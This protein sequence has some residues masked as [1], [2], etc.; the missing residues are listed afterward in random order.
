[1][2]SSSC[3]SERALREI[4]L[5]GFEIAVRKSS[6]AF[7]MNSYNLINGVHTSERHDLITDVLRSEFGFEGAVMTDWIVP[8]MTNKNSEWSYPDPAKVAAAG[9]SVFMPGTKHDYE[10]ILTGHKTG[11][12]TREQLEINVTRLLQ[13]AS[14]Q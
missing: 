11:K 13:F 9:T 8:G 14:E 6:P 5:R 12:V 2:A 7:V 4:Y 3:V 1:M 10:D